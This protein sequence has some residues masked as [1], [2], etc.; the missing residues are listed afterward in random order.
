MY[1]RRSEQLQ[2]HPVC[3]KNKHWSPVLYKVTFNTS[4]FPENNME[5]DTHESTSCLNWIRRKDN[6]LWRFKPQKCSLIM[7]ICHFQQFWD[8]SVVVF[9]FKSRLFRRR[10]LVLLF[11]CFSVLYLVAVIVVVTVIINL[12]GVFCCCSFTCSCCC[13]LCCL[14]CS[15]LR[16]ANMLLVFVLSFSFTVSYY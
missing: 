13:S 8:V 9:F 14:L 7:L 16:C 4:V 6:I 3:E 1:Y 11:L 2:Q 10:F 12:V 5:I 15:G